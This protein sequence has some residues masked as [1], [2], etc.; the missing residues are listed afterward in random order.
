MQ[1]LVDGQATAVNEVT[2]A[3]TLCAVHVAP[4]SVLVTT[5]PVPALVVPTAKQSVALG[6]AT[7]ESCL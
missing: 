5:P 1:L 7:A 6:Q 4:P 2:A 3:G